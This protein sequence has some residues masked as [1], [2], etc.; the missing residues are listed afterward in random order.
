MDRVGVEPTT[1][2]ALSRML[3]IPYLKGADMEREMYCS[4]PTRSNF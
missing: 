2:A 3:F 1:S 4:N